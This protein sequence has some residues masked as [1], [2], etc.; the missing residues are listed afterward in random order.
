MLVSD[1]EITKGMKANHI[2]DI[3]TVSEGLDICKQ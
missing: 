1:F 2:Y 3:L